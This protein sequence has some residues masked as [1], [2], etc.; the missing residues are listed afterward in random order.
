MKKIKV[1]VLDFDGVVIPESEMFKKESWEHLFPHDSESGRALQE[2]EARFGRGRGGDRF[3]ILRYVYKTIG[4][5]D[6]DIESRVAEGAGV[7]DD[8]VQRRIIETGITVQNR[9]VIEGLKNKGYRMYLNSAT[10]LEV[11][12]RTVENLRVTDLFDGV[13]GRPHS[14]VQNLLLI[15]QQEQV[16]PDEILFVGDSPSDLKA[17]R[18]F[19]C[20]FVAVQNQG[21]LVGEKEGV[22]SVSELVAVLPVLG[23]TLG[24][25]N[26]REWDLS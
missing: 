18:E 16:Q 12:R 25:E 26:T 10:P 14:K 8:F 5:E 6:A 17:A 3:D 24:H 7:F 11:M 13:L 4:T 19:G 2:A 21:D 9:Q 15:T 20:G 22:T 23:L 1:I